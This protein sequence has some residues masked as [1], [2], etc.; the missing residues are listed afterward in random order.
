MKLRWLKITLIVFVLIL[1]LIPVG[2]WW[3]INNEKASRG[4]WQQV[5][6]LLEQQISVES[7]NSPLRKGIELHNVKFYSDTQFIHIKHLKLVWQL[8]GLTSRFLKISEL[9]LDGVNVVLLKSDEKSDFDPLAKIELPFQIQLDDF[10][11]T[12]LHIKQQ[13]NHYQIDKVQ[14]SAATVDNELQLSSLKFQGE[15]VTATVKGHSRLGEGFKFGIKVN[16]QFSH[17]E[18]GIWGGVLTAKGDSSEV[19]FDNQLLSP[20]ILNQQGLVE[21]LLKNPTLT[22]RGTWQNLQYPL[23]GKI[24]QISSQAGDFKATGSAQTYQIQLNAKLKQEKIPPAQLHFQG[25]GTQKDLH[26]KQLQLLTPSGNLQV[27]GDVGWEK[28]TQFD[29]SASADHFNPAIVA[30]DMSGDLDLKTQL[31]GQILAEKLRLD[32]DIAYL[33]GKLRNYPLFAEGQLQLNDKDLTVKNINLTSGENKVSAKGKLGE[34]NA[35]LDILIAAPQLH[36]LWKGLGG[37][38]NATAHL[39]GELANPSIQLKA[40]GKQLRFAEHGV[41]EFAITTDYAADGKKPSHLQLTATGL[42]SGKNQISKLQL[43]GQGILKQHSFHTVVNS[44]D[45][46]LELALSGTWHDNRWQARLSELKLFQSLAGHWQLKQPTDVFI[47]KHSKGVDVVLNKSCFSQT[48]AFIC[49]QGSYP[50]NGNFQADLHAVLPTEL[51]KKYFP[52]GMKLDGQIQIKANAQ[53]DSG[54]M[55]G[56]YQ[57]SLGKNT[58]LAVTVDKQV[59]KLVLN[60]VSLTGRLQNTRLNNNLDIVYADKNYLRGQLDFDTENNQAMTGQLSAELMDFS[61]LAPYIMPLSELKGNLTAAVALAG[62]LTKPQVSGQVLLNNTSVKVETA[63]IQLQDMNLKLQTQAASPNHVVITGSVRSGAGKLN[64]NGTAQI[65]PDS[66]YPAQLRISGSEFEVVKLPQANITIAPDLKCEYGKQGGSVLG[67]ITVDKA[68]IE[69]AELP[70]N[71]AVPSEDEQII[72][73]EVAKVDPKAPAPPFAVDI[74]LDLGKSAS[75]T[76]VGMKTQLSG[77]LQL[78]KKGEQLAM[79]GDVVMDK[80]RYK[81]YGQDLTMR[82]GK[83]VFNGSPSNPLLDVEAI[84]LSKSKKVTAVLKV[85]GTLQ[86]PKTQILSEPELP[87]ADA[88]AYLIT[89]SSLNQLSKSEGNMLANA[90]LSYGAGQMSWLTEK[91][92]IDEMEV[93][94]GET[95]KDS[96]LA[97]GQY[98]TPDFYV[99]ARVGLFNK[100]TSIVTKYKVTDAIS[101][102]TQSGDSQRVNVNYEFSFE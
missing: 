52:T 68:K 4:L 78:T 70:A 26:I 71:A 10:S 61:P 96:L 8:E 16:W 87:E 60:T 32:I 37:Q 101:I 66:G 75:F 36:T 1:V 46:D 13:Q 57:L 73:E 2:A 14:F 81:S 56:Q 11:L 102:G 15:G 90:A 100:Q 21:N 65:E 27:Q 77:K 39:Q 79:F 42:N 69:L 88:L 76:G 28:G 83:F 84:R 23:T 55:R 19:S 41:K 44:P 30:P 38:L 31:K 25:Q 3:L 64:L 9:K 74:A 22:T 35:A 72:G 48:T 50:A 93:E 97:I 80:G 20:F 62:T 98:L 53:K 7:I 6:S 89:G 45:G 59:T 12:N 29:L 40:T 67:K 5:F 51:G 94:Q 34:K 33:K 92:G 86:N 82:R 43:S 91:F 49:L 58:P 99:G 85:S 63:G 47:S 18:Q 24:I 17:P 54:G 95:L